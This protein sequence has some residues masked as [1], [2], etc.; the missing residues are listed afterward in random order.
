MRTAVTAIDLPPLDQ[1]RLLR[2][3]ERVALGVVREPVLVAVL[4]AGEARHARR[5]ERQV[6]RAAATPPIV[7]PCHPRPP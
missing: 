6:V 2:L 5:L 7:K 3:V 1:V 4:P